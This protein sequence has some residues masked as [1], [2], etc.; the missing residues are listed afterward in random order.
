MKKKNL[1]WTFFIF[2]IGI[3]LKLT[4]FR[5]HTMDEHAWNFS[6]FV[7]LIEVYYTNGL[8]PFLRLFLGNIG[9]FVPFG[10]LIPF[11]LQR[12]TFWKVTC[13]GCLFSFLIE[14]L[15][16]IF[17]KG[18]AELDDLIL[19]TLGCMLGYGIYHFFTKTKWKRT[20]NFS[21]EQPKKMEKNS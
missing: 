5:Q 19:N 9:W 11:L 13:G 16:F 21:N 14:V 18:Y 7:Q 15:Q 17:R 10:F 20:K 1:L 3:V 2:Y 6:L 8:W 12:K 4:I